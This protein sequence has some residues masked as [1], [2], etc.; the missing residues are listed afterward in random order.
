MADL[1]KYIKISDR[2]VAVSGHLDNINPNLDIPAQMKHSGKVYQVTEIGENAF[3]GCIT[4]QS[5]NLEQIKKIQTKAF[6]GCEQLHSVQFTDHL[7]YIGEHAFAWSGIKSIVFPQNLSAIGQY[8]FVGCEKLTLIV[9]F[10]STPPHISNK[11]FDQS[12]YTS[13]T[14]YVQPDAIELYEKDDNWKKFKNIHS[15]SELKNLPNLGNEEEEEE[16]DEEEQDKDLIFTENVIFRISENDK[17][18]V[19]VEQCNPDLAGTLHLP[20]TVGYEGKIYLVTEIEKGALENCEKLQQI[21]IPANI[22]YIPFG[23][24]AHC[25]SLQ[26]IRVDAGNQSFCDKDGVLFDKYGNILLCY[27]KGR[28]EKSYQVPPTTVGLAPASFIDCTKLESIYLFDNIS[29]I[30]I[31]AFYNCTSLRTISLPISLNELSGGAFYKCDKL[32]SVYVQGSAP[33]ETNDPF[34]DD[35][36]KRATLYVSRDNLQKYKAADLWNKFGKIKMLDDISIDN[37]AMTF[38]PNGSQTATLINVD[39]KL[40]GALSIPGTITYKDNTYTVDRIGRNS[41]EDC[42][43]LTSIQLPET[44]TSIGYRSV[45]LCSGIKNLVLPQNLR[46]IEN[47]AFCFNLSL[48]TIFLPEKLEAIG[49]NAFNGDLKLQEIKIDANN[50][51]YICQDGVLYDRRGALIAYPAAK[52]DE[53][54]LLPDSVDAMNNTTFADAGNLTRFEVSANNQYYSTIDGVLVTKDHSILIAYPR[55]R[56]DRA[57]TV[58]GSIKQISQR[59]FSKSKIS[60]L[61]L[62]AGLQTFEEGAFFD[63]QDLVQVDLPEGLTEISERCFLWCEKLEKVELPESIEKIG[64]AAFMSCRSLEHIK[65]PKRLTRIDKATFSDCVSLSHIELPEELESIGDH[66][67]ANCPQLT[68][69]SIP[70]SVNSIGESAFA[71]TFT[72]LGMLTCMLNNEGNLSIVMNGET[73]PA[74]AENTFDQYCYNRVSLIVPENAVKNYRKTEGW[75]KFK[76]IMTANGQKKTKKGSGILEDKDFKYKLIGTNQVELTKYK[77]NRAETLTIAPQVS[78]NGTPYTITKIAESAFEE[79]DIYGITIEAPVEVIEKYAFANCNFLHYV[80]LPKTLREIGIGAFGGCATLKQ[81]NL[82]QNLKELGIEAFAECRCLATIGIPESLDKINYHTFYNC[83]SLTSISLPSTIESIEEGAFGK[84]P[85]LKSIYLSNGLKEIGEKAFEYCDSLTDIMLPDSVEMINDE[86]FRYCGNL[87]Q[88]DLPEQLN[89]MGNAVFKKCRNLSKLYLSTECDRYAVVDNVLYTKD[90]SELLYHPSAYVRDYSYTTSDSVKSI[91]DY[92]FEGCHITEITISG[93]TTAIGDYCFQN[94]KIESIQ[95]PA[96]LKSLG[97]N[98][99]SGCK[100]LKTATL[101]EKVTHIKEGLF[102]N[103]S[104]LE[105]VQLPEKMKA[106]DSLAFKGCS[107][108]KSIVIKGDNCSIAEKAFEDCKALV[109]VKLYGIKEAGSPAF[110]NC[111]I[112]D[113][114]LSEDSGIDIKKAIK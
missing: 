17:K 12:T 51:H 92:A 104:K 68:G 112:K 44:I 13:G 89:Y 94:S 24:F 76:N 42:R 91:S 79:T 110:Y 57:Y 48:T 26:H 93:K 86:A 73:P 10:A 43:K 8:A 113:L 40:S 78:F 54:Y 99:F 70:A 103:C 111:N 83:Q 34:D 96:K 31:Q 72:E 41:I 32:E 66:A 67:F 6:A 27:P 36:L 11:S 7:T 74:I 9:S 39:K 23:T 84:C 65:L 53:C 56:K 80:K 100:A 108:L 1:L 101:P 62:S 46:F 109:S 14:V 59:A 30:G 3:S 85:E 77:H 28:K 55:G 22:S 29:L 50:Q 52:K 106:I 2:E 16:E 47:E 82:P 61:D 20:E 37:G 102:R 81:I 63:C 38:R 105:Q 58:D 69:I 33:A 25:D 90:Q 4:L 97:A 107:A 18:Q 5:V 21:H 114:F 35:T 19:C 87:T 71:N 45:C 95:L 49:N 60:H 88:V 98:A 64:S 75:T 15:I